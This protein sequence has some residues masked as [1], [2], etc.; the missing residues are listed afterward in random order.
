[1]REDIRHIQKRWLITGQLELLTPTHLSNGDA[2][3]GVDLPIVTDPLE[4]R[5]LLPGA[6]LAGALRH[7]LN[8]YL[9]HYDQTEKGREENATSGASLIFGGVRGRDDGEQ[10]A[11]IVQD[12][13]GEIPQIELRDGVHINPVTRTAT[14]QAKY[15]LQLLAAGTTFSL[16]FELVIT[17]G[18]DEKR[19]RHM[20]GAAL[21]GLQAGE[22]PLGGRKQRGFGACRVK[23]WQVWEYD[24]TQADDLKAWLAHGRAESQWVT[25]QRPPASGDDILPLLNLK[26]ASLPADQ[27]QQ[28]QVEATLAIQGSLLIRSGFEQS[29]GPDV[30]HLTSHRPGEKEPVP[31]LSGTSLAGVMRGQALRIARTLAGANGRVKADALVDDLFGLMVEK[32]KRASRVRVA[33]TTIKGD[34]RN[35]VQSRVRIDR[36]TGGAFESALFEEQPV[37]GGLAT[38]SFHIDHPQDR[39]IGLLLLVLKDLWTGYTP[40]GGETSVGRGRL[41]GQSACLVYHHP[42]EP[43]TWELKSQGEQLDIQG[44]KARLEQYVQTLVSYLQGG[45]Q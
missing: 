5:A 41:Q 4:G 26:P 10:S 9:G 24:L 19:V 37:F 25:Q 31:V 39:E 42:T 8:S 15:D 33:E 28:F 20:L 1:M 14:D 30:A 3:P 23:Q 16:G 36:F 38:L 27:R 18:M 34:T 22:I 6:S 12:A 45:K 13:L 7:Y 32:R 17:Q 43:M 29:S 2:D 35:L 11:F 40:V 21:S 44:D